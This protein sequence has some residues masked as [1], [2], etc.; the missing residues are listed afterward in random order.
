M[1]SIP[2]P[3]RMQISN[4]QSSDLRMPPN[5]QLQIS[6]CQLKEYAEWSSQM[7]EGGHYY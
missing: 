3:I 7:W 2:S 5:A 4:S 1:S 6:S